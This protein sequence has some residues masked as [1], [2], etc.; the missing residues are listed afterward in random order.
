MG[1]FVLQLGLILIVI[2]VVAVSVPDLIESSL[3]GYVPA[4]KD[5]GPG[6]RLTVGELVVDGAE[7]SPQEIEAQVVRLINEQRRAAGVAPLKIDPA[8]VQVARLRGQDMVQRQYFSHLDPQTGDLLFHTLLLERGIEGG[9]ENLF[10]VEGQLVQV[11]ERAVA[12]WMSSHSHAQNVVRAT[13]RRTG[14]GVVAS[15]V[16]LYITQIFA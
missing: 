9:G 11:A 8:L 12:W 1:R 2:T 7:V 13:Y 10:L 6:Q 4:G 14:V 5:A 15:G 3:A 16:R